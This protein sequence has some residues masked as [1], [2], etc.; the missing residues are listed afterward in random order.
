VGFVIWL[1]TA[2]YFV[3]CVVLIIIV[4]MQEPKG[5]GLSSAFGGAGL[6]TA[7]GASIGRKMSS[8][9][10]YLAVFFLVMTILLAIVTKGGSSVI[11]GSGMEGMGEKGAAGA[12]QPKKEPEK[13]AA[14]QQQKEDK[15]KPISPEGAGN[16]AP[17][18]NTS[19][20]ETAVEGQS[21]GVKKTPP[22]PA[23]EPTPGPE[24][25]PAP[26]KDK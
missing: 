1:L 11:S 16:K 25:S 14:P 23:K 22:A 9:T 6:D 7:F 19:P 17:A 2:V 8:F 21:G 13:P 24:K 5:G 15:Q 18:E 26:E 10:V 4:L 20:K 12:N 3:T